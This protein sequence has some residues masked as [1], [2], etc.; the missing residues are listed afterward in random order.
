MSF[1]P[2]PYRYRRARRARLDRIDKILIAAVLIF[3]M[4]CLSGYFT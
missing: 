4:I 3:A 1:T 2:A